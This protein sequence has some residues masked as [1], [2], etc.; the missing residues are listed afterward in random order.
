[1][2]GQDLGGLTLPPGVY[3]FSSSAQLTGTLILDAQNDPNAQF[4][5]QIGS[6]LTTAGASAVNVINGGANNSLIWQVGSSATLGTT[7]LFAG[8]I[9]ALTS[10]SLL[11]GAEILCGRAIARNGAVTMDA[12]IIS[13][14]CTTQVFSGRE[15]FGS[16]GF[17]GGTPGGGNGTVPEP[18]TLLLLGSGLA[19]IAA[20]RR[21]QAA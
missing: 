10:I 14:N 12:N 4:V 21:K 15:D 13:N 5:F 9:I 2:T 11:T 18:A 8:N 7:T 3:F 19:G 20:W 17:S 1:M 6:T 16:S